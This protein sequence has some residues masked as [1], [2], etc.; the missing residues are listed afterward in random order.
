MEQNESTL[1]LPLSVISP[2]DI[3]RI[4][5]EV[6]NLDEFFRQSAIR[7]GGQPQTAPRYSRL[8]DEVV[9]ANNLN[10]LQVDSRSQLIQSLRSF[11]DYAPVMHISF[12]VDPPGPYVQKIVDWIRTNIDPHVLIR[13]GLQPNIGAGCVVRTT[14][15]S[16]DFSLRKYFDNKREF[17]AEK[18]HEAVKPELADTDYVAQT[19]VQD[20]T[21]ADNQGMKVEVITEQQ[22]VR[23]P[24]AEPSAQQSPP[25]PIDVSQPEPEVEAPVAPEVNQEPQS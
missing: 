20:N 5:R 13:V 15:K 19:T 10:L 9:V 1:T 23:Q 21:S 25:T 3:A 7:E 11:A 6:E 17:F 8:L 2:T 22:Q 24:S 4:T 12:S 16:F 18:L 14:N